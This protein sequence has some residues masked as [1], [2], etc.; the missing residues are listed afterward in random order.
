MATLPEV[1]PSSSSGESVPCECFVNPTAR[2]ASIRAELLSTPYS[3]CMER[4]KLLEQFWRSKEGRQSAKT[5]HPLVIAHWACNI[6]FLIACPAFTK[7]N[8]LS[9]I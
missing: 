3:I 7:T 9:V 2:I 4:P 5:E 8:L 6:F 1:M